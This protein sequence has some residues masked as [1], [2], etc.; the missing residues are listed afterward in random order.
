MISKEKF[1]EIINRLKATHE[2]IEQVNNILR[3]CRDS[4]E[5]EF[6]QCSSLMICHEDMVIELL[7]NIFD[8]DDT[9]SWWIY[10]LDFGTKFDIGCMWYYR[11][12][13]KIEPD[14]S[15]AEKLYDYLIEQR[16]EK[17]EDTR[18]ESI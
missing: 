1:V 9:L 16:R 10:D 6:T 12:G 18:E 4:V 11:D 14:L 17:N 3:N 15:T 8:E 13:K 2:T 7:D 5:A